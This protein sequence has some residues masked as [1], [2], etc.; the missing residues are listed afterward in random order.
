MQRGKFCE[1]IERQICE[2][3]GKTEVE[4]SSSSLE[5]EKK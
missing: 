4:F 5:E 2:G 3:G 1:D